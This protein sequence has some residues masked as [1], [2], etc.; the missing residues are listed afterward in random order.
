MVVSDVHAIGKDACIH[1]MEIRACCYDCRL[2]PLY[3]LLT[4]LPILDH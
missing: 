3:A 1:L 2:V 4:P